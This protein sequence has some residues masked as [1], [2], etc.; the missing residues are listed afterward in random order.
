MLTFSS[1]MRYM[2]AVTG[3]DKESKEIDLRYLFGLRRNG[4]VAGQL[5]LYDNRHST[6]KLDPNYIPGLRRYLSRSIAF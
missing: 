6:A 5:T 1:L 2:M 4:N 3:M